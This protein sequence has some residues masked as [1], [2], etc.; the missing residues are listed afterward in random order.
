MDSVRARQ[1]PITM[2]TSAT[3][4]S[5]YVVFDIGSLETLM[6]AV[7]IP[8]DSQCRRSSA[9]CV[10]RSVVDEETIRPGHSLE[11]VLCVPFIALTLMVGWQERQLFHKKPIP[12]NSQTFSFRT[13]GG[14]GPEGNQLIQVHQGKQPLN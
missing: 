3:A 8:S 4:V 6:L 7:F 12:I 1:P 14:G 2:I 9:P 11:S 10:R 13:G 5:R